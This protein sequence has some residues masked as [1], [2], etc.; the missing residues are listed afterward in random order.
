MLRWDLI[1]TAQVPGSGERLRLMRRG[2]EFSIRLDAG[3]LMGSR[4]RGSEEALAR[5]GCA[6]LVA[7][8]NARVLIGGLGMG[9]TLG[10]ALALLGSGAEVTVAELVPAVAEWGRGPLAAFSG[11]GLADPR[12]TLHVGDVGLLMG[13]SQARFDAILLDVDNGPEGLTRKGNDRLY[14]HAGLQ[15]ARAALRPGGVLSIWS[16]APDPAFT[17]RLKRNGFSVEEVPVRAHGARGTRHLIW[18][19][20]RSG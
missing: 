7:R 4:M 6:K 13:A 10:A 8:D 5:L 14:D 1:D 19:A 15:V 9:F 17:Q 3:V 2:N 12:V 16:V 11:N 20:T 18:I